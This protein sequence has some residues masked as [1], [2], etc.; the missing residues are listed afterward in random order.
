MNR[1]NIFNL[2]TIAVI[3]LA[4]MPGNAFAQQ[5]SFKQQLMGAW[6]L[7]S[8]ETTTKEGV[9]VPF[10]EGTD[11]RGLLVFTDNHFSFQVI[12]DFPK[13]ASGDRLKT[14]PEENK[15][16]AHGVQS[17]FGTYTVDEA[18]KSFTTHTE[19]G[20]QPNQNGGDSKRNVTSLTATELKFSTPLG[21]GNTN[22]LVWK[23]AE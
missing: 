12:A 20:S 3:G 15:A 10:I 9:K 18:A 2:T 1:R 8:V 6:S 7:V 4:S 22:S 17:Y 16:V 11:P 14:T 21:S 5:K 23:R 13:L 19:R